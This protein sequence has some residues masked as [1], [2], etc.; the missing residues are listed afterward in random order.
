MLALNDVTAVDVADLAGEHAVHE[1]GDENHLGQWERREPDSN[2]VQEALPAGAAER[3]GHHVTTNRHRIETQV[4]APDLVEQLLW[5]D[6]HEA[7]EGDQNGDADD[8]AEPGPD[9]EE[10][11]AEVDLRVW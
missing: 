10:S 1:P 11:S 8:E 6:V 7:K 9:V 4:H 3:K 2:V 5:I